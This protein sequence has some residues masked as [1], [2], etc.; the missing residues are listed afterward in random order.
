MRA[1]EFRAP[2][3][4]SDDT[5]VSP[6]DAAKRMNVTMPELDDLIRR[7]AVRTRRTGWG[8]EVEPCIVNVTPRPENLLA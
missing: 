8:I 1:D 4:S 3:P 7:G 2:P 5:F 6:E